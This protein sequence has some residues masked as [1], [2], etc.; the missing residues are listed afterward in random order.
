MKPI[1]MCTRFYRN[2]P[3]EAGVV[4]VWRWLRIRVGVLDLS[5]SQNITSQHGQVQ[6][7]SAHQL[8]SILFVSTC[9]PSLY[10]AGQTLPSDEGKQIMA[11]IKGPLSF[12]GRTQ[13]GDNRASAGARVH[14]DGGEGESGVW[15]RGEV[16]VCVCV[17]R[18]GSMPLPHTK[19]ALK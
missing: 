2:V 16:C 17:G 4:G 5:V 18:G 19:A 13:Q 7:F 15:D 6:I 12:C 1:V 10:K 11:R 14:G 9:S 3:P 8:L